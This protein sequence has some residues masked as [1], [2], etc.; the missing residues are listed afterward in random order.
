M[1]MRD[2][3]GTPSRA[4]L[5]CLALYRVT[6]PY[7]RGISGQKGH[8]VGVARVPCRD[9]GLEARGSAVSPAIEDD[10]RVFFR[11]EKGRQPVEFL[12]GNVHGTRYMA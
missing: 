5:R 11:G 10:G 7:P 3:G 12:L 9:R 4:G 6:L 8:D 1:S 2:S